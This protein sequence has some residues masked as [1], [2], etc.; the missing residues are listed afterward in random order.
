LGELLCI[1]IDTNKILQAVLPISYL[2][3]CPFKPDYQRYYLLS[4]E[5]HVIVWLDAWWCLT[6]LSTIFQLYRGDQFYGWRK[7][8]QY[9]VG[10]NK[11]A[12]KFT[13][14]QCI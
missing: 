3:T 1:F 8:E 4:I 7:P 11:N 9:F 6:P 14:Q 5:K 13:Q 2:S 10:I 12:Q